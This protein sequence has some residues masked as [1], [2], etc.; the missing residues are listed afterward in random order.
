M[1]KMEDSYL[2]EVAKD[3]REEAVVIFDRGVMD[4][5]AY[6]SPEA[7]EYFKSNCGYDLNAL[8]DSRYDLVIHMVTAADG[9]SKFYTLENN[10]ARSESPERAIEV[11][12]LIRQQWEGHKNLR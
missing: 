10:V 8:R 3:T 6:M 12:R 5:L 7:R 2:Q 1:M 11:D 4:N 9:A